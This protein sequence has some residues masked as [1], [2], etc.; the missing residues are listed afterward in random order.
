M[1][2][3]A[4]IGLCGVCLVFGTVG[5]WIAALMFSDGSKADDIAERYGPRG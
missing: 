3:L 4:I 1:H 2:T 5:G